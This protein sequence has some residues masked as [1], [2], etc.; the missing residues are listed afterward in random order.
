MPTMPIPRT[1]SSYRPYPGTRAPG[2][3][4]DSASARALA[5]TMSRDRA[6]MASATAETAHLRGLPTPSR[7]VDGLRLDMQVASSDFAFRDA[8]RGEQEV[9]YQLAADP[10]LEKR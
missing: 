4:A 10:T 1:L 9:I 6:R 3:R 7:P 2:A 5:G 8:V